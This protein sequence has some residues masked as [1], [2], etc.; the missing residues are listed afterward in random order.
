MHYIAL[1]V[2]NT[3]GVSDIHPFADFSWFH[4]ACLFVI[5]QSV[6]E[7]VTESVPLLTEKFCLADS[8]CVRVWQTS[9]S[10]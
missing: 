8:V 9:A 6:T 4:K 2:S 10:C 3:E 5:G 1:L 7:G